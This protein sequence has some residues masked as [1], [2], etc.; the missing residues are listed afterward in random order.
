MYNIFVVRESQVCF[1]VLGR[2]SLGGSLI[3]I[4]NGFS[5]NFLAVFVQ[6][7]YIGTVGSVWVLV[8]IR[9]LLWILDH[10]PGFSNFSIVR[11]SKL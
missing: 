8:A 4:M 7:V 5:C 2:V 6:Q 11:I 1:C 3:K 10:Y 9:I